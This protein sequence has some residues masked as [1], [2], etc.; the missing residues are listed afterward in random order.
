[1][2]IIAPCS[3]CGTR[4]P[5]YGLTSHGMYCAECSPYADCAECGLVHSRDQLISHGDALV[6]VNCD[7][8]IASLAASVVATGA[9][10]TE[11]AW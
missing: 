3:T 5:I 2:T 10:E 1:M 11:V 8:A 4:G 7:G 9:T 6:C